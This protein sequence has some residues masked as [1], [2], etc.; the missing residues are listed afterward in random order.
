MAWSSSGERSNKFYLYKAS[1]RK[2]GA[3]LEG[4]YNSLHVITSKPQD[5]SAEVYKFYSNLYSSNPPSTDSIQSFI[6]SS[7]PSYSQV[8]IFYPITPEEVTEAIKTSP[9]N[10]SPGPD[11]IPFEVYRKFSNQLSPI[12]TKLFNQCM[13]DL[14]LLPGSNESIV[15]TLF[16]KGDKSDLANWR[17]IALSNS[18][19]KLLT[20]ILANRLNVIASKIL[21]PHQYGFIQGRSIHNN[22][23]LVANALREPSTQGALCFFTKKKHMIELTGAIFLYV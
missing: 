15:V 14:L 13:S 7:G 18:D 1:A 22:I 3:Q 6:S 21:S 10:K 23:N 12:L 4:V 5:T 11:G 16:K 9:Q 17:P 8:D 19:L 20:K 2:S